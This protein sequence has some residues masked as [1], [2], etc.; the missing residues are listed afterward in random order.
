M[1]LPLLLINYFSPMSHQP[2][3]VSKAFQTVY[4][5]GSIREPRRQSSI[6]SHLQQRPSENS[7]RKTLKKRR[8]Q[9]YPSRPPFPLS[10]FIHKVPFASASST[11]PPI[12]LLLHRFEC[13][14]HLHLRHTAP[15]KASR[16]VAVDWIG[17]RCAYISYINFAGY[18]ES[19]EVLKKKTFI[20]LSSTGSC[21]R[22]GKKIKMKGIHLRLKCGGERSWG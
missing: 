19:C 4:S 3:F 15:R 18:G 1:L 12:L 2:A 21:C 16:S 13:R 11:S 14:P 6:S 9:P 22:V 10:I 8:N 20:V 17:N 5:I 7:Q